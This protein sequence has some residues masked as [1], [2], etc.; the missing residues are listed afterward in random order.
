MINPA[1]IERLKQQIR[2]EDVVE[3]EGI[4]LKK[5]GAQ[6]VGL[7]AFHDDHHPSM[8]VYGGRNQ[9]YCPV[10]NEHGD[11]IAFIMKLKGISYIEALIY[12]AGIYNM[13]L[14]EVQS[15]VSD[16][17]LRRAE[18]LR[19]MRNEIV[20]LSVESLHAKENKAYKY[21][22]SR[23]FTNETLAA[24]HVGYLPP[25]NEWRNEHARL[26]QFNEA[27]SMENRII[28][29]WYGNSNQLVA[30]AG[31]VLNPATKGVEKKY[32][33]SSFSKGN[34]FFGWS[35]AINMMRKTEA[36]FIVEGY[37]DVMAM[38]QS[39]VTNA[40]AQCGTALTDSHAYI[41]AS[42]VKKVILCLD[43]DEAGIMA[44]ERAAHKLLPYNLQVE[45][46]FS[47]EGKDP[48]DM[49]YEHGEEYV[50]EWSRHDTVNILDFCINKIRMTP[51]T[52]TFILNARIHQLLNYLSL[53]HDDIL[54]G[55][56]FAKC[57]E[58]IPEVSVQTLMEAIK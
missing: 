26:Q 28:F 7:C 42:N 9:F 16:S 57:N 8:I 5:K 50:N 39:G 45:L 3:H 52:Q 2:I 46:L 38:Y 4:I 20:A 35:Q 1:D 12:I 23:G 47:S 48:A 22:A 21:M 34:Y 32:V 55:L 15:A 25:C 36:V 51:I 31:R 41:L 24:Y 43:N 40:I 14:H 27:K 13:E 44:M 53:I 56:Y 18:W 6:S 29:P 30:L 37:T 11:A 19:T 58:I 33:N 49:M 17:E 10:C 54:R